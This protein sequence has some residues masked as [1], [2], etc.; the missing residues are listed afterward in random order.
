MLQSIVS[1]G[2]Q[3]DPHLTVMKNLWN[4][5]RTKVFTNYSA[6][7]LRTL[8]EWVVEKMSSLAQNG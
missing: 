8:I 2:S 7:G 6:K 3:N 1:K 4:S 5:I